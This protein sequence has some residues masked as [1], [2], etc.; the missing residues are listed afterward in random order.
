MLDQQ[1]TP[2]FDTDAINIAC[3]TLKKLQALFGDELTIK[4]YISGSQQKILIYAED[5]DAEMKLRR[6]MKVCYPDLAP[7]HIPL[8]SL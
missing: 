8:L 7:K 5:Q 1:T 2:V 6:H 4:H 3:E